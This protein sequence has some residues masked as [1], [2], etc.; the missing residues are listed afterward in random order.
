MF[1]CQCLESIIVYWCY[2]ENITWEN[3]VRTC[4]ELNN[5]SVCELLF[6]DFWV[7]FKFAECLIVLQSFKYIYIINKKK[8]IQDVTDVNT[9]VGS[10][11][12]M[13]IWCISLPKFTKMDVE[14]IWRWKYIK[15]VQNSWW[16]LHYLTCLITKPHFFITMN[17][18]Y[19]RLLIQFNQTCKYVNSSLQMTR[20]HVYWNAINCKESAYFIVSV[21]KC[22][23]YI[24]WSM[25]IVK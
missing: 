23:K 14:Q 13:N 11:I 7:S 1:L 25:N 22:K 18:S 20:Y 21:W 6:E 16:V 24:S 10:E 4:W 2:L 8:L 15:S 5:S 12:C 9:H 3:L 17:F 19:W